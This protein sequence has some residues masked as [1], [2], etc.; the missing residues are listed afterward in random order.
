MKR[1]IRYILAIITFATS[2][3]ASKAVV[4]TPDTII[5][6]KYPHL[7]VVS[8][9]PTMKSPHTTTERA[10]IATVEPFWTLLKKALEDIPE[11]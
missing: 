7:D 2:F 9:G 11:K 8:F 4:I 6:G 5:L 10:L 1:S 3:A